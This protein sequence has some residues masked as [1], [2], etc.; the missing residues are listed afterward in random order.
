MD[1]S[2]VAIPDWPHELGLVYVAGPMTGRPKWNYPAFE[3]MT[4]KLR[5]KGHKV[6][7]PHE[8]HKPDASVAWDWY[9]RRDLSQLVK[10]SQMVMLPGWGSSRGA[11]LE[12]HVGKTLGM[13]IH[14]PGDSFE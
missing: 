12:H 2:E 10:C 13:T 6:I 9:L 11:N 1:W 4:T 5:D 3:D 7:G 8:L 14:Y